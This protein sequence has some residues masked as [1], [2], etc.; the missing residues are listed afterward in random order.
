M[1]AC[2]VCGHVVNNLGGKRRHEAATG[3][4]GWIDRWIS[5]N[6]SE[7]RGRIAPG[8]GYSEI[9][10][11]VHEGREF[12][13]GG[14]AV[15]D[16]HLIA[17]LG[18][19][20]TVTTWDGHVIGQYRVLSTWKTPRSMWSSTMSSV[21][22]RLHDGRTYTGRSAGVGMTV[23][24]RRSKRWEKTRGFVPGRAP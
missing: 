15:T 4:H 10:S 12:K 7:H 9:G 24:A 16:A 2:R 21:V 23:K 13:A 22:V 6:P 18:K 20:F 5:K 14:A 8:L 11:F 3:H 19:D 17:Y 1:Y